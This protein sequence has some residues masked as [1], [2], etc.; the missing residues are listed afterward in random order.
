MSKL[1]NTKT[2]KRKYCKQP[3]PVPRSFDPGIT[4]QRKSFI[5]GSHWKW[6]NGT[7]IK[8]MFIEGPEPQK[9]VVRRAFKIWKDVGIGI[10]FKEVS[11]VGESMVR[12]GF[13]F[14]DGS[15]SYVGRDILT[16]PK[17]D[18]TMNFGWDLTADS[19]GMTT[20]IHE[21][22]HT[23]GFQHEHQSPFSGIVWDTK[24]VYKE[25]SGPP[26]SWPKKEIDTN[27]INKLPANQVKGSKWDPKSIM[28]YEFGPKLVLKPVKYKMGIFPPGILSANDIKGVKSFY[29]VIAQ[30]SIQKVQPKKSTVIKAGTGGQS[31][32]V[33][34]APS[35]NKFTFETT[36]KLDTVMVISEKGKT[37]NFYLGGDDDSGLKKNAKLTLP[38]V[39]GRQYLINVRVTYAPASQSGSVIVS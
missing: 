39:K 30:K 31:D 35:T 3:A 33:F 2:T 6:V 29:P 37:E 27:I 1:T 5:L 24:A 7:E 28:E 11:T 17:T 21:I 32:F 9:N 34:I 13:D 12:I 20:A 25:F 23:I 26:N 16:I 4:Q 38:L 10:S 14:T 22:G 8:Y 15:W 18:R 36:G 19:Y